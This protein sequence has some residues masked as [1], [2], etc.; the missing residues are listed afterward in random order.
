M[1]KNENLENILLSVLSGLLYI[2]LRLIMHEKIRGV[3]YYDGG[4]LSYDSY[5][6]YA[7]AEE[8]TRTGHSLLFQNPFGSLDKEPHLVNFYA[9]FLKILNPLYRNDLGSN[10]YISNILVSH[11]FVVT[12]TNHR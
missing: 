9:S 10:I 1:K 11:D 12:S 4:L 8:M 7:F 6:H 2:G 3:G 5:Y